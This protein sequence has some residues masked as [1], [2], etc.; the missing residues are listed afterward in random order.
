MVVN[1]D[2]LTDKINRKHDVVFTD[3]LL[4]HVGPDKI[5]KVIQELL[6]VC[7]K[8][9]VFLEWHLEEDQTKGLGIWMGGRWTR[10]YREL[11]KR[12]S[13]EIQVS[14]IKLPVEYWPDKHW[15][16]YGYLIKVTLSKNES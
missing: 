5:L 13:P 12:I 14:F 9:L 11:L 1:A 4:I 8:Y 10:N 6:E 15:A 16:K 3:A 7:S 2:K